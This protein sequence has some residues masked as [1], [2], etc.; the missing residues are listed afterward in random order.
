[1]I[2]GY[3]LTQICARVNPLLMVK[4]VRLIF[5]ILY[6]IILIKVRGVLSFAVALHANSAGAGGRNIKGAMLYICK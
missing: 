6:D 2:Y 4:Y 3:I 5:Y 1:M